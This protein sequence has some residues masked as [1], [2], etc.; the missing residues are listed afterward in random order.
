KAGHPESEAT[1]SALRV[2]G[3]LAGLVQTHLLALHLA[4]IAGQEARLAQCRAQAFVVIDQGPGQTMANRAGLAEAATPLDRDTNIEAVFR[5][6]HLQRLAHDH[7]RDLAAEI[8]VQR[9]LIDLDVAGARRQEYPRTGGL[10]APGS[11]IGRCHLLV[12]PYRSSARG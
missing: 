7:A 11:V 12:L 6:R 10:A 5:F 9:A 1:L 4:G 2:L 8:I 3:P